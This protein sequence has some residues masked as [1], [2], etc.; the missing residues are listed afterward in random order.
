[1]TEYTVDILTARRVAGLE[2]VYQWINANDPPSP[3]NPLQAPW[4][5]ETEPGVWAYPD[6]QSYMAFVMNAAC[7][8][9]ADIGGI[10]SEN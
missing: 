5:V 7:E 9:Y 6:A 8:S 2:W 4:I 1:M 10:P 3:S